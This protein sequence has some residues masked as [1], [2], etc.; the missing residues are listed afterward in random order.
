MKN[1]MKNTV[2]PS[3]N[4]IILGL[5]YLVF[6][7]YLLPQGLQKVN[8]LLSFPLSNIEVNL[9][10]FVINA[11]A[12]GLIFRKFLARALRE[13]VQRMPKVLGFA[14]VGFV[15][16]QLASYLV[17]LLVLWLEPDFYN[18]NDA[19]IAMMVS[20]NFPMMFLCTVILVPITEELLF[21]GMLFRGLFDRSPV[22]AYA[23]SIVLFAFIHL[24]AYLPYLDIRWLALSFLQYLPASLFLALSYHLSGSILSPML[25]HAAVNALAILSF[26]S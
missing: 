21:R 15:G 17:N 10:Y 14:L 23:A 9:L 25:I 26:L 22:L 6:Y 11:L 20:R 18:V 8:H 2:K 12:V 3:K 1:A 13:C 24:V 4:S 5:I 16:L 19:S 7:L